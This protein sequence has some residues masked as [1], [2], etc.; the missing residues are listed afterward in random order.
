L[1]ASILKR[2]VCT[3]DLLTA[4]FIFLLIIISL[5]LLLLLL[6][7][8][9]LL[10]STGGAALLLLLGGASLVL[11]GLGSGTN[12]H[13][14]LL[15]IR[16]D[17]LAVIDLYSQIERLVLHLLPLYVLLSRRN[18]LL[19]L[20]GRGLAGLRR[21]RLLSLLRHFLLFVVFDLLLF[22]VIVFIQLQGLPVLSCEPSI[23]IVTLHFIDLFF[24]IQI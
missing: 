22:R 21:R 1:K 8:N 18:P 15:F 24:E 2:V 19:L 5:L 6:H 12:V 7:G 3:W 14:I 17:F 10:P 23:I 11:L 9:H 20:L 4:L 16:V 13:L